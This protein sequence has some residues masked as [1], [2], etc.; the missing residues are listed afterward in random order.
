[1]RKLG[2]VLLMTVASSLASGC[3]RIDGTACDGWKPIYPTAHD[4]EVIS[5]RL[6]DD[7]LGHNEHGR[8][9]CGWK[10]AVR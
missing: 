10:R 4:V 3:A 7:I 6:N 2:I 5:Q 9:I 8:G 1:M